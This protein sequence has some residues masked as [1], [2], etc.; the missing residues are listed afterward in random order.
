VALVP[1]YKAH[2]VAYGTV[3]LV[4]DELVPQ[5]PVVREV[6]A[7][8]GIPVVGAADCEADD[9]IGTLATRATIPT[10]IVTGDRDLFQLVDDD[11]R[12]RVLY[13][14][15]GVANHDR[16][17]ASW[18]RAKYGIDGAGYV[19]FAVLRGDPSDGLPGVAGVGEKTA[20]KLVDQYG[21]LHGIIGA[22]TDRKLAATLTV[23]LAAAIDY[24]GPAREVVAVRTD[25]DL[26]DLDLTLPSAPPDPEE[27]AALAE[28]LGL[29]GS[30][31][32]ILAA[33]A[34]A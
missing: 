10:E 1:S 17:D 3:E 31:D 19:D 34:R 9:V 23:K 7:T 11:R 32:R 27:F 15:R 30:A 13:C 21:D 18:L 28:V 22:A 6:L 12:V 8:L 26:P 5:V 25:V 29:G 33:M 20:A 4:P 14:G 16:V 24:L 2:R